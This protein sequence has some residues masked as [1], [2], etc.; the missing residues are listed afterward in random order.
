[1]TPLIRV[2]SILIAPVTILIALS[3][4]L[5]AESGPGDG[6]T[7]GIISALALT[8][9]YETVASRDLPAWLV[10]PRFERL[11]LAG[12]GGVLMGAIVPLLAGQ[13]VLALVEWTVEV[14][15]LGGLTLSQAKLFEVGLALAVFGGAMT[16]IINLRRPEERQ[17]E[18][19]PQVQPE[20]EGKA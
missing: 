1:M 4:L 17:A 13:N 12:L 8:L 10:N 19:E 7:A 3:H 14:P 16:A 11:L 15:L 9:Q 2:V 5:Q 18:A 20:N 6:F